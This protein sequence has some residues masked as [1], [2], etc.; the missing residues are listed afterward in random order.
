MPA[1]IDIYD[2]DAFVDGPPHA[3]FEELRRT[4][5]VYWQE[6]RN[7]GGYWAVLKHADVREVA[8]QPDIFSAREKGVQIETP[9]PDQLEIARGMLTNM[10]PPRHTAHR[11][12]MVASFTPKAIGRL[13]D[14]VREITRTILAEAEKRC[15]DTGRVE[16]VHEV[17]SHLPTRVFGE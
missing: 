14:R 17:C 13:E 3:Q 5:P 7:G 6:L 2:P 9:P 12:P 4:Q 16:F 10:D 1:K 8:R 15:E 11:E